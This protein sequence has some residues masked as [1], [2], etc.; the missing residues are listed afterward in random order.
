[1]SNK[2]DKEPTLPSV[3]VA[4]GL[5]KCESA[6]SPA[7]PAMSATLPPWLRTWMSNR[8]HQ[9]LSSATMHRDSMSRQRDSWDGSKSG[10][11]FYSV[12]FSQSRIGVVKYVFNR[13]T[14]KVCDNCFLAMF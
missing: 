6:A 7:M 13:S 12:D 2:Q 14:I 4:S 5:L 3:T 1:M 8:T 9:T 10:H 11:Q